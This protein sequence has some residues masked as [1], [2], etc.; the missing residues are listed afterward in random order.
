MVVS[1]TPSDVNILFQMR[2]W[3]FLSL[4]AWV[5]VAVGAKDNSTHRR[6]KRQFEADHCDPAYC[7]IPVSFLAWSDLGWPGHQLK[8]RSLRSQSA[9]SL[10]SLMV[11][12][13]TKLEGKFS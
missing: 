4:S 13:L 2:L 6:S 11:N 1:I 5:C 8:V 12:N 9:M 3:A 7:Q 10:E